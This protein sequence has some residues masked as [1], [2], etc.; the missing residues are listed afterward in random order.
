MFTATNLSFVLKTHLSWL[1]S[2]VLLVSP[3][4]SLTM[5]PPLA[6]HISPSVTWMV[7]FVLMMPTA[8]YLLTTHPLPRSLPEL[9]TC[10]F[11]YLDLT[12]P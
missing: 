2:N 3:V 7:S 9:E 8:I 6:H 10:T 4:L 12:S 1:L 11:K 5:L